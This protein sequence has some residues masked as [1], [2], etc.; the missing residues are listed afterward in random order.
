VLL[1]VRPRDKVDKK[2][3][4][5]YINEIDGIISVSELN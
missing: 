2:K 1:T 5:S 4:I 3:V